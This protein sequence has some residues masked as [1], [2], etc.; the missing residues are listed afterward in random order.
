M[1]TKEIT[2]RAGD[3]GRAQ[4]AQVKA[5]GPTPLKSVLKRVAQLHP[6]PNN[7]RTHSPRQIRQIADSIERFGFTNPIL[8][9]D[10]NEVIGG[11]ARLA[12]AKLLGLE[13]VPT[14]RLSGM[15][16]VEKRAYMIA[17]NRLAE[18]AGWDRKM[19]AVEFAAIA[20]LDCEF[21]L[22]LT[23]FEIE[24]IELILDAAT[25]PDPRLDEEMAGPAS[26]P[27]ICAP[28][29]LWQLGPHRL[30]CGD[31]TQWVSYRALMG[32]ERARLVCADPPYNLRISGFVS[33]LG[34][35]RH[36]EFV[37]AS[38]EMSEPQ[39]IGFL[40][41]A[42]A[43]MARASLSGSL[44][45]LFI[46]WRHL[47]EMLTAGRAVYDELKNVCVWMKTNAGM[48]S[49]YRSQHELICV[50]KKGRRSHIDNVALGRHGRSR[51]NVWQYAG[52]NSFS[53]TRDEDLASH[54]TVKSIPLVSDL[55][56]D[57]SDRGD[58]VLD[59]FGGSG[60]TLIAVEQT[61]R[62]C[63]MMELDPL[64]CDVI[65]RRFANHSGTEP[66]HIATG[67]TFA[68]LAA[69]RAEARNG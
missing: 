64:Y 63:R 17:D 16:S 3:G 7:S 13:R 67:K 58:I 47:F 35:H 18:R 41:R 44:H 45:Y 46:D 48:G 20:E 53:P 43:R 50:F 34:K 21:D 9:S 40:T 57:A 65:L 22:E 42:M 6:S 33:G 51:S 30:Y 38:G 55:I 23:G 10:D 28:G 31:A 49:L 59:P 29:D 36:R 25:D 66:V 62:V 39:Y 32:A 56:L 68:E 54:P 12:A 19:L 69:E 60:T 24:D 8:I 2:R 4:P 15:S 37:E 11:H 27:A 14:I 61:G 52:A 1:T 26:G 5:C